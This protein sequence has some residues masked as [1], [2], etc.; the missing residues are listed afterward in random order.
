MFRGE[1]KV[2][3]RWTWA[4]LETH[5]SRLQQALK[6]AGVGRGDRVAGLLPNR[7]EAVAAMLATAS[8]GA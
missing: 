6:N 3:L 2:R 8:L 5:V 1:D 7:P 4:D